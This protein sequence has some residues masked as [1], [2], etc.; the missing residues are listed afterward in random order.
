[1]PK[2]I[3]FL[4]HTHTCRKDTFN[5]PGQ[6]QV[7]HC[8]IVIQQDVAPLTYENIIEPLQPFKEKKVPGTEHTFFIFSREGIYNAVKSTKVEGKG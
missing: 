5:R 2:K 6:D 1:M 3:I 8:N 4:S 7:L